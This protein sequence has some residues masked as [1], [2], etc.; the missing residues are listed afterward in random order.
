MYIASETR[1]ESMSYNRCEKS[2]L[3]VPAVSL[4]F[5]HNFGDTASYLVILSRKKR[6]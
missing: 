4:G 5:W 6:M 1:Y 3:K 2:G